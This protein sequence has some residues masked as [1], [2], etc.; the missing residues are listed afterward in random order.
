[1]KN[2]TSLFTCL[3]LFFKNKKKN[4]FFFLLLKGI[5]VEKYGF[6]DDFFQK[7]SKTPSFSPESKIND[8]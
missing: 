3:K 8:T 4:K 6:F 7:K 2:L 5:L 1:M